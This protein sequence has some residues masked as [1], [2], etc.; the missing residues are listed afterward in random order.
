M[1]PDL[2]TIKPGAFLLYNTPGDLV[3]EIITRTGPAAHVEFYEGN[4]QSLASRNGVGVDRYPYRKEGLIGILYPKTG[5]NS[6][7]DYVKAFTTWF[8]TVKGDGYDWKGLEGF[9]VDSVTQSQAHWFCSAF[10]S[11]G[12]EM[13][14]FPLFNPMWSC[15]LITPSDFF[16]T[17]ALHWEWV[18]TAQLF[19]KSV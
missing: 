13:A 18:D 7:D 15:S 4:G 16:K 11:K 19:N 8:E 5:W 1:Q 3:D 2:S 6:L 10:A 9:V 12:S 17:P 14:G